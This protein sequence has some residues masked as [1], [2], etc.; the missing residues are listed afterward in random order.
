[1]DDNTFP[2]LMAILTGYNQTTSYEL[3]DPKK[4][5]HLGKLS[6][7]IIFHIQHCNSIKSRQMPVCVERLSK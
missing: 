7:S 5:G 4:V 3:C 2:N 1:M 6:N